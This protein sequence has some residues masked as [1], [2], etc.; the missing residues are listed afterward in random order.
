VV[1]AVIERVNRELGT[2]TVLITHNAPIA[3]IAQRVVT[4]ADGRIA[5]EDTPERRRAARELVWRAGRSP[6]WSG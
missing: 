1:L 3:Q 4:L 2:V 5:R 6:R